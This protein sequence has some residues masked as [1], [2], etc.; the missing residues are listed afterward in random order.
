MDTLLINAR[1]RY[2]VS[3]WNNTHPLGGDL[4][5]PSETALRSELKER[6]TQ[7][8][9][10]FDIRTHKMAAGI[11]AF[12]FIAH[13]EESKDEKWVKLPG[14][15]HDHY[16]IVA[17]P[18]D[19][20]V[21]EL[22]WNMLRVVTS[23]GH[24]KQI[25]DAIARGQIPQTTT[26]FYDILY[27]APQWGYGSSFNNWPN[28]REFTMSMT[29]GSTS[30]CEFGC[31]L[32]SD[33]FRNCEAGLVFNTSSIGTGNDVS[34]ATLSLY[35]IGSSITTASGYFEVYLD[36]WMADYAWGNADKRAGSSM[37]GRL[38]YRAVGWGWSVGGYND[39]TSDA[40]FASNVS[41]DGLTTLMLS[42]SYISSGVPYS[43]GGGWSERAQCDNG[44]SNI[45]TVTYAP[46]ADPS[47]TAS[48]EI[49]YDHKVYWPTSKVYDNS[50]TSPWQLRYVC[51]EG[52]MPEE[53]EFFDSS[54]TPVANA[55]WD[56]ALP[57]PQ[58][59]LQI[60]SGK[61]VA[62]LYY[63][64]PV[65]DNGLCRIDAYIISDGVTISG[66]TQQTLTHTNNLVSFVGI[67]IT[68][69]GTP[70]AIADIADTTCYVHF[71]VYS[72]SGSGTVL[73]PVPTDLI[74]TVGASH[75]GIETNQPTLTAWSRSTPVVVLESPPA[76]SHA[77]PTRLNGPPIIK[78]TCD[79]LYPYDVVQVVAYADTERDRGHAP[80]WT[81]KQIDSAT[82][83]D[84]TVLV[85]PP[86][87]IVRRYVEIGSA[88]P[89]ILDPPDAARD[90]APGVVCWLP[91][92]YYQIGDI[93]VPTYPWSNYYTMAALA[94]GSTSSTEPVWPCDGSSVADG[95][96]IWDDSGQRFVWGTNSYY[97]LTID[98]PT[99]NNWATIALE[100]LL[101]TGMPLWIDT[102]LDP[103]QLLCM[104][105][106]TSEDEL[107]LKCHPGPKHLLSPNPLALEIE[108]V[109][110]DGRRYYFYPGYTW[111]QYIGR[112]PGS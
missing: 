75:L 60:P 67:E 23:E 110:P 79:G 50:P 91:S 89:Y 98:G 37:T 19:K 54:R 3:K 21:E 81:R 48:Y 11:E 59:G 7:R 83:Q 24:Q 86:G 109:G 64:M 5:L 96:C 49:D 15:P 65:A 36:D 61:Y 33:Y 30:Y 12:S 31:R 78:L 73:Y 32:E 108:L 2:A 94:A 76:G 40:A 53:R 66:T 72:Y 39:F 101:D 97:V 41:R 62:N 104:P 84:L 42:H 92:R 45:L 22:M 9:R 38:A 93:V 105:D 8:L 44:G 56:L 29:L 102:N 99:G 13:L 34:A 103:P 18:P 51:E 68:V 10:A 77:D 17:P 14:D 112:L 74:G 55:Y 16:L 71:K 35:G 46:P 57:I 88:T 111:E 82:I 106:C 58:G 85:M 43:Y 90:N 87:P 25:A 28:A 107:T 6:E 20:D 1:A 100:A 27:D 47:T 80:D 63:K 69:S 70:P 52:V 26:Q 4:E 95:D